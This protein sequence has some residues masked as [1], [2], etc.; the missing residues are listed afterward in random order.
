MD[1]YLFIRSAFPLKKVRFV[2]FICAIVRRCCSYFVPLCATYSEPCTLL[3]G[4]RMY[5][6]VRQND[7]NMQRVLR[8]RFDIFTLLDQMNV[9]RPHYLVAKRGEGCIEPIIFEDKDFIEIGGRRISKPFIESLLMPMITTC[10][11][12]TQAAAAAAVVACFENATAKVANSF[13]TVH[14][15]GVRVHRLSYSVRFSVQRET[16]CIVHLRK[17]CAAGARPRHQSL[18]CRCGALFPLSRCHTLTHAPTGSDYV[19]A[20]ARKAPSVDGAIERLPSGF[21]ARTAVELTAAERETVLRVARV[22]RQAVCGMDLLRLADRT[23]VIDVNGWSF[24][25]ND[26]AFYERCADHL[27]ETFTQERRL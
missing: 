6:I 26:T 2:L 17:L 20:E 13:L 1:C 12:T 19:H 24:V 14:K 7:L 25:K 18:R 11:F 15:I 5:L 4:L 21:E 10:V 16:R 27:A 8:N 3:F 23:L 22:F 9:P